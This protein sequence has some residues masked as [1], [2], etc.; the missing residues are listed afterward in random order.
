MP[1]YEGFFPGDAYPEDGIIIT[2]QVKDTQTFVSKAV[3]ARLSRTQEGLKQPE[4]L[5]LGL[6]G[7]SGVA[8]EAWWME[9]LEELPEEEQE[10]VKLKT[11]P[12]PLRQRRG[13]LIRS[14]IEEKGR[15][16][17]KE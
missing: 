11:R 4:P 1:E 15:E 13:F 16:E 3:K 17:S 2:L 10:E 9:V 5:L 14:L 7:S 6:S 12:V 8:R